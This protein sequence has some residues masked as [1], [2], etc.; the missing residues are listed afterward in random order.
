MEANYDFS[1]GKRG[2]IAPTP[3]GKTRLTVRLDDDVLAWFREQAHFAGGG[4]YQ[5]LINTALRQHIEH[6]QEPMKDG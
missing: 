3:A 5:T 1:K 4:D 6:Q 2:A